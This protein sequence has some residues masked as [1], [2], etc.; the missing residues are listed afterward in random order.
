M[1]LKTVYCIDMQVVFLVPKKFLSV[2][3]HIPDYINII[4]VHVTSKEMIFVVR[5][6]YR[7]YL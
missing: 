3:N 6:L 7:E 2:V 1:W 4:I 5:Q